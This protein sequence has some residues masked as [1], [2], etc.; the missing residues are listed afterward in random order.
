[1]GIEENI[2]EHFKGKKKTNEYIAKQ[3]S[4]VI[5]RP[6]FLDGKCNDFLVK[7]KSSQNPDSCTNKKMS[8]CDLIEKEYLSGIFKPG[9]HSTTKA[10]HVFNELWT[11]NFLNG[12]FDKIAKQEF[13]KD[14]ID[15][16]PYNQPEP[17]LRVMDISGGKVNQSCVN[18]LR[19]VEQLGKYEKSKY[20]VSTNKLKIL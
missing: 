18:E 5:L 11:N 16:C 20:L 13:E 14:F 8:L 19:N 15:Q 7:N 1:M 2:L 6:S 9:T 3:V 10:S 12:A 17:V 4:D